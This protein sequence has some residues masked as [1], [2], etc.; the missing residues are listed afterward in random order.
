MS[1]KLSDFID[2][3]F[4]AISSDAELPAEFKIALLRLQLPIHKLSQTDPGFLTNP[5]HPARRTLFITKQLSKHIKN[6]SDVSITE[7]ILSELFNSNPNASKF[8]AINRQL[9]K[10]TQTLQKKH[11][12]H[13][14]NNLDP[15]THFKKIVNHK[16]KHCIQGCDIPTPCQDLILKLWPTTLFYLLKKH[17]INST[18]WVKALS[19]F[20]ELL[21]AIQPIQNPKQY[22]LLKISYMNIVRRNNHLL[23]RYNHEDIV[24]T[25]IKSLLSHFNHML[26]NSEFVVKQTSS[27]TQSVQQKITLLPSNV[28]PGV[29]CEIF[30]DD[31][32]PTRRLRL[33]LIN[34]HTGM[35]IF[36][37]RKGIKMLEKDAA[38]FTNELNKGLSKIYKHDALFTKPASKSQFRK[39]G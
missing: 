7:R 39:I 20:N 27:D 24:E 18:Q 11:K 8:S 30:I 22:K 34:N 25:S 9:E 32:V 13:S 31:A 38:E 3:L 6:S 19:I 17:N 14:Q 2:Q 37:N 5:K 26:R 35:L 21:N 12:E 33:A 10:F 23:Q 1:D 29:W 16:V 36:V 4:N 28:K 15:N